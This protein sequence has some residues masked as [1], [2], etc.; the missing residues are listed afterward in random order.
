LD[1][2]GG[3]YG[4]PAITY[5]IDYSGAIISELTHAP[6]MQ[7]PVVHWTPSIAPSGLAFYTGDAFPNWRG[8][9]FVGALK[10]RHLRRLEMQGD[11]VIAQEVLL[12][13]YARIRDVANGPDGYL[14]ILTDAGDGELLRLEPVE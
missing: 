13:G 14:Y 12:D 5:G 2:P 1:A 8:D 6:G 3:N 9:A 11:T 7:Q 4:W 10:S